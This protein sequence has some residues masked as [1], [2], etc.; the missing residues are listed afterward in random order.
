MSNRPKPKIKKS[1]SASVCVRPSSY[2]N[3][4]RNRQ[5]K[6]EKIKNDMT[7]GAGITF[8]PKLND[9]FNNLTV[10]GN[11]E[12]R[13]KEF[14][15]RKE[16]KFSANKYSSDADKE[17]TF[18]PKINDNILVN[19][20]FEERLDKYNIQYENNKEEIRLKYEKTFPF[21]PEISANT[22]DILSNRRYYLEKANEL[23]EAYFGGANPGDIESANAYSNN[24]STVP[25]S[26]PE[27]MQEEIA[28]SSKQEIKEI[29]DEENNSITNYESKEIRNIPM[30][31]NL[32][33]SSATNLK[34]SSGTFNDDKALELAKMKLSV[35]ESLEKFQLRYQNKLEEKKPQVQK[36]SHLKSNS[37]FR[38]SEYYDQL[39]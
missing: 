34:L 13:S 22:D 8:K 17:C 38:D 37:L 14:L 28:V 16:E 25:I 19:D 11:L 15:I 26:K 7:V 27:K 6:I 31:S 9:S 23:N 5:K 21:F 33:K 10:A 29:S 20:T 39:I 3:Y 35:D 32:L 24:A 18:N 1:S 4:F 12:E 36:W 2:D 30:S